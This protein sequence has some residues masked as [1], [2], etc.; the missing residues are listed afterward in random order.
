MATVERTFT[1][2]SDPAAT[3]AYMADFANA[4]EWD[5]GTVACTPVV[6]GQPV[7][8]GSRW[9]NTSKVLG[10]TTELVYEIVELTDDRVV[11]EGTNQSATTIDT[12]TVAP[13]ASG[14]TDLTYRVT[15]H[16]GGWMK[17]L[18]PVMRLYFHRVGVKTEDALVDI[19]GRPA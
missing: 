15:I 6:A 17:V 4:T 16:L 1:V 7:E 2:S 12:I 14:G 19:L 10:N 18:D 11:L 13:A 9:D 3:L 5:P 8:V